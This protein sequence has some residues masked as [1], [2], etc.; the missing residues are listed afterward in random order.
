MDSNL[1]PATVVAKRNNGLVRWAEAQPVVTVEDVR[2]AYL[3]RRL[4]ITPQLAFH[5]GSLA[6][7]EGRPQ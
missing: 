4:R 3:N 7:G 6:F 5:I 1:S 2:T